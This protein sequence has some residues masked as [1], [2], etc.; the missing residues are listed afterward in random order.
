[1]S[2]NAMLNVLY[3]AGYKSIITIHGLRGT[4]ST[5]L[6]EQQFGYDVIES[7]LAHIDPNK[8]R[9]AYNH[10]QYFEERKIMIKL[11]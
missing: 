9:E 2:E 1:M 11:F 4:G 6:N 5:I 3:K 7:A 8:I 10:A